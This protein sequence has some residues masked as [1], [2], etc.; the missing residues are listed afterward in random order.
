MRDSSV[1]GICVV[2]PFQ[3]CVF[4]NGQSSVV[5]RLSLVVMVEPKRQFDCEWTF[6]NI[7]NEYKHIN[8]DLILRSM[9]INGIVIGR[10][11]NC[12]HKYQN[13]GKNQFSEWN[14]F[15]ERFSDSLSSI[16]QILWQILTMQ[17][18]KTPTRL[19][20]PETYQITGSSSNRE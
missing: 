13:N 2:Q 10:A 7:S 4:Q 5:P 12:S 16:A 8:S 18:K 15:V 1:S 3:F 6:Q 9:N 20:V 19:H 11:H 17:P 14:L